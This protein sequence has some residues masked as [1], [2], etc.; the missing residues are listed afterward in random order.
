MKE[1]SELPSKS[2][3]HLF[4]RKRI[5]LQTRETRIRRCVCNDRTIILALSAFGEPGTLTL[6]FDATTLRLQRW[7]LEDEDHHR[8]IV[9]LERCLYGETISAHI[10]QAVRL[11]NEGI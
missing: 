8:T 9:D 7:I 1:Y 10:F 5:S 2:P 3:L 6:I 4:L 11:P